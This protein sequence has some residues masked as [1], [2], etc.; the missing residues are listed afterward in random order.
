MPILPAEP[1]IFTEN[2][3]EADPPSEGAPEQ[4]W[5]LYTLPRR[6]KTLMRWLRS[7][8]FPH[9]APLIKHR[10]RSPGGRTLQSYVPLFPSY[11]FFNGD[12]MARSRAMTSKCIARCLAV[13]DPVQLVR[14]LRQ[15]RLLVINGTPLTPE[16]RLIPGA[17]VRIR[18]GA[19]AGTEGTILKRHG[20]DRLLVVVHF[21]QRGVSI[22]IDDFQV[23]KI[24]G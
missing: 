22:Q 11:V 1:D 14:D 20:V 7:A 21:L 3:L 8:G 24:D 17:R 5:A 9:Y 6:E 4:W 19:M 10:S 18:S 23:E 2:L 13:D 16:S 15:V 12:D